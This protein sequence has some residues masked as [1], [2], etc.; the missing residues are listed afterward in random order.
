MIGAVGIVTS[1]TRSVSLL[2][3]NGKISTA[4]EISFQSG[5]FLCRVCILDVESQAEALAA[6]LCSTM[7]EIVLEA[8]V[9][10]F[11]AI[12]PMFL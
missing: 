1:L 4:S 2:Q 3:H 11:A 10:T 5:V 6:F 7:M 9:R 12:P 8:I